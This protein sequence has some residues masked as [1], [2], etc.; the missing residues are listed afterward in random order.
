MKVLKMKNTVQK[1][2][3]RAIITL[4][5]IMGVFTLL[6]AFLYVYKSLFT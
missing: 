1:K 3:S 4:Y 2:A 6:P 5:I